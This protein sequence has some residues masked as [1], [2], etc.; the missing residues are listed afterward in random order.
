MHDLINVVL[1][2]G[3]AP[4]ISSGRNAQDVVEVL[5]GFVVSALIGRVGASALYDAVQ[6][7][8]DAEQWALD[9]GPLAEREL[10]IGETRVSSHKF[11][12]QNV[13]V[14]VSTPISKCTE[15]CVKP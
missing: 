4:I 14:R 3:A 15:S 12:S 5:S 1:S 13:K 11:T 9:G 6:E 8:L 10:E 7:L 2:D